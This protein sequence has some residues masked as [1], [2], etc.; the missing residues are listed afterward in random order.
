[1]RRGIVGIGRKPPLRHMGI[2]LNREDRVRRHRKQIIDGS[3]EGGEV[4]LSLPFP[5]VV[6]I[7][8]Q[9]E[10][11]DPR[12]GGEIELEKP[13]LGHAPD[14]VPENR[15]DLPAIHQDEGPCA[16]A[17]ERGLR[18]RRGR[19]SGAAH[20][21]QHRIA[22]QRDIVVGQI[23][24]PAAGFDMR[25]RIGQGNGLARL[26][27]VAPGRHRQVIIARHPGI[28]NQPEIQPGERGRRQRVDPDGHPARFQLDRK[29]FAGRANI[30]VAD[31]IGPR[32]GGRRI[33]E[34]HHRAVDAFRNPVFEI[35]GRI[36]APA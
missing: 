17:G 20:R 11:F 23:K 36:A 2:N 14:A 10:I 26:P 6:E 21:R 25:Q 28:G 27:A 19:G 1:M 30:A 12:R 5:E 32:G 24:F 31:H 8:Y 35:A 16:D 29:K 9:P 3:V 7:G 15:I 22:A 34:R 4:V 18:Q 33:A 13:V